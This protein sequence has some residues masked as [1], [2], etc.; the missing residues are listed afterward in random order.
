MSRMLKKEFDIVYAIRQ[1]SGFG[2]D[3]SRGLPTASVEVWRVYLDHH[4]EAT[5]CR[6]K[7]FPLYDQLAS[8]FLGVR[9][10]GT[11]ARTAS[12]QSQVEESDGSREALR[13]TG[14]ISQSYSVDD[15]SRLLDIDSQCGLG[16]EDDERESC[17]PL[18]S[19]QQ[20][21]FPYQRCVSDSLDSTIN[22]T[23]TITLLATKRLKQR[24]VTQAS[25]CKALTQATYEMVYQREHG[26]PSKRERA[27]KTLEECYS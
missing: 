21:S 20:N 2:W 16:N 1:D 14:G 24:K 4:K 10:T 11:F 12:I 26:M 25:L 27:I 5:K 15:L 3:N 9:V 7:A 8:L 13:R 23:P 19:S 18:M 17:S 6:H 22:S